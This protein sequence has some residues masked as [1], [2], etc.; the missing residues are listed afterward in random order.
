[1]PS[2]RPLDIEKTSITRPPNAKKMPSIPEGK[3]TRAKAKEYMALPTD[4][5]D[6]LKKLIAD[7]ITKD[8]QQLLPLQIT[9]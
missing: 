6:D 2:T 7:Q 1:M 4:N 9:Q 5:M 3:I 8:L